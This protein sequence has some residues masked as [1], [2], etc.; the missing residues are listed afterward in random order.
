MGKMF[1][2][3]I[4]NRMCGYVSCKDLEFQSCSMKVVGAEFADRGVRREGAVRT[5][6]VRINCQIRGMSGRC[7]TIVTNARSTPSERDVP[8]GINNIIFLTG[9]TFSMLAAF[10]GPIIMASNKK[11]SSISSYDS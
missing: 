10:K 7:Y 4:L 11:S 2:G 6:H 8:S 9:L 5:A 1:V 3:C